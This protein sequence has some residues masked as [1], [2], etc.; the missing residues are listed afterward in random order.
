MSYS[1][2]EGKEGDLVV[3]V[4]HIPGVTAS[5]ALPNFRITFGY[6]DCPVSFQHSPGQP[7][8]VHLTAK[9]PS[10]SDTQF[11]SHQLELQLLV[12]GT[13]V[14]I[15]KFSYQEPA[16]RQSAPHL[17]SPS[18]ALPQLKKRKADDEFEP[19]KTTP[20]KR[21]ILQNIRPKKESFYFS[22]MGPP[23]TSYH[24][25]TQP[26]D[27]GYV[28][29]NSYDQTTNSIPIL[30]RSPHSGYP[31][32]LPEVTQ[33]SQV[34]PLTNSHVNWN[35]NFHRSPSALSGPIP[36]LKPEPISI[37]AASSHTQLLARSP[38]DANPPLIRTSTL[39]TGVHSGA[40]GGGFNP[41]GIY[42]HKAILAVQGN[43][44]SMASNWSADEWDNRRRLV[45]FWRQQ[46]GNTIHAT[47]QPVLSSERHPPSICISCIWWQEK[48][49]CY[50]TSVDCIALLESLIA[51]RFTV[52]EKNRIRRNLE[53]FKP[54]TV[55]KGKP[56]SENFFKLI[57]A[58]PDPKPR[59]IE[60]DVK[61][62][63]WKILHEA[64]KKIIGKYVCVWAPSY[65]NL[66]TLF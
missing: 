37:P 25:Y 51:V 62:F 31:Y 44:D 30:D 15:G 18:T 21:P 61:V 54:L 32:T 47:F 8:D 52:E 66:L 17:T 59:N 4:V 9:V 5:S 29:G 57:M 53:G 45:Q 10:F 64:L 43:L 23:A 26:S 36:A 34:S 58:F 41:Y 55:S 27:R 48:G 22:E 28:Y 60:K 42:P 1:P 11:S 38:S 2:R 20:V 63:P 65:D 6:Y 3:V 13:K 49:E 19:E 39:Q 24:T 12:D 56:E 40:R 50:V 14:P 16:R 35:P 33:S 46:K 7:G